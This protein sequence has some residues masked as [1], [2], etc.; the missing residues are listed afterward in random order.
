VYVEIRKRIMMGEF[1]PTTRLFE[2]R[3]AEEMGHSRTPVREALIRLWT[4]GML[5]KRDGGYY[6][7]LPDLTEL[8]D[9]YEL[10]ITI[11]LRG[12]TRVIESDV[13]RHDVRILEQ[14]RDHWRGLELSPPEPDP[15]FVEADESF[16]H[17]LLASSGNPALVSALD[18]VNERIRP[19]RMYDFL[20]EDRVRD[21]IVEHLEI[22]DLTL[23]GKLPD[24]LM[25]LRRH[26]GESL[27]VVEQRAVR[28]YTQMTLHRALRLATTHPCRSGGMLV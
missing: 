2:E 26:V 14:L 17:A 18:S 25:A 10:R 6:P 20:T 21:T 1:G 22:V 23:A 15:S 28:A 9:L 12:F 24:A 4:N 16:H 3:I 8:R 19:I 11:E 13:A 5:E 7:A 27:E